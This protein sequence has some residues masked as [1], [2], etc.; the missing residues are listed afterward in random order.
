[1]TETTED[2]FLG[3]SLSLLQ[4]KT[5]YRAGADP[6]LLA[7]AV[8]ALATQSVLEL[9][10]GV[11]VALFCLMQRGAREPAVLRQIAR[12]TLDGVYARGGQGRGHAFRAL[13]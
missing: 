8:D 11:G 1:M 3:G 4:P 2:K 12:N 5:G 7:S 10:C 6:V 13:D 9:G